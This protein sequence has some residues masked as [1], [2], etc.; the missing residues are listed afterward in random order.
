VKPLLAIL[1]GFML[2]LGMFA[3][4][5]AVAIYV[6]A[7]E[8]V[9][10]SGPAMDVADLWSAQ[11]RKVD[12]ATQH[13]ERL[14]AQQAAP[15]PASPTEPRIAAPDATTT[16]SVLPAASED[17]QRQ[18]ASNDQSAHAE[19][20]ASR[21]RSYRAEDDSYTS[22]SGARRPCLSPLSDALAS[23]AD[24]M[25][26]GAKSY[27]EFEGEAIAAHYAADDAV[28]VDSDHASYCFDRYRSYRLEDNTY[29]PFGGGPRRQCR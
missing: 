8:P 6:L 21:Y 15:Q 13:F 29:Q 23:V 14:P 19:W 3:G 7:V 10:Q 17:S 9:D 28:Y 1:S 11:P 24:R 25:L 4:G 20:C 16:A 22:Y 26:A 18:P 27:A 5:V 12:T 2:S